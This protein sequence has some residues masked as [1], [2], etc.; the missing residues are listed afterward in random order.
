MRRMV[1]L[2]SFCPVSHGHHWGVSVSAFPIFRPPQDAR[3]SQNVN[4]SIALCKSLVPLDTT[5]RP[6][7]A[8]GMAKRKLRTGAVEAVFR[9][10]P[11]TLTELACELGVTVSALSQWHRIPAEH[12]IKVEE[13]TEISRYKLR[14]DIFGRAPKKSSANDRRAA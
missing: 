7:Y 11:G 14:P 4:P 3:K 13:L 6:Q 9:N 1:A 8:G 10:F 5:K 12:V 2:S